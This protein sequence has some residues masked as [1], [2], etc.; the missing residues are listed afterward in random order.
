MVGKQRDDI[1]VKMHISNVKKLAFYSV[2]F[3][4]KFCSYYEESNKK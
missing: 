1:D 3:S 4:F 2:L